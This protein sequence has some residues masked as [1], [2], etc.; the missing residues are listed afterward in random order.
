MNVSKSTIP[1]AAAGLLLGWISMGALWL[2]DQPRK[3]DPETSPPVTTLV[4]GKI[5]GLS[6]L[7]AGTTI[8]DPRISLR[9]L[10]RLAEDASLM[11]PVAAVRSAEGIKGHDNREEFFGTALRTWGETDGK[12][13]AEWVLKEYQG[14]KLSDALY[15]V[16]DGWAE[17][18][19][20]AAGDWFLANSDGPVLEDAV[21]EVL[22]AWGRKDPEKAL[23][24]SGKLDEIAQAGVLVGLAEGWGAVDPAAA[25]KAGIS[26]KRELRYDFLTSV[27]SQ[28]AGSDPESLGNWAKS[29]LAED[30][31]SGVFLEMGKAWARSDPKAAAVWGSALESESDRYKLRE[32][33][34]IGWSEHDPG[35]ALEWAMNSEGDPAARNEMMGDII[36]NW[37]NLDPSGTTEWLDRQPAGSG[38]DTIL[39]VFSDVIVGQDPMAAVAWAN[40]IADTE[41]R[42]QHLRDLV[43][44]WFEAEGG[45]SLEAMKTLG[46]PAD[47]IKEVGG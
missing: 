7:P 22:E 4:P 14:E 6:K 17:A 11:D 34:A 30:L 2:V 8:D 12:S 37:S 3:E 10:G 35:G 26:L 43:R 13:A 18:D 32:G 15:Y 29:L 9:Q 19:P 39:E 45:E 5:A 23:E 46:V 42:R 38:K 33:I 41:T 1:A 44:R 24:W 40:Q 21:W 36:F 16:A 28:W 25:A 47:L 31:R 27:A 20:E